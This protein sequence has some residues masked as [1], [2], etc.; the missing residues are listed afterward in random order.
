MAPVTE[1]VERS[2]G[3]ASSFK[4]DFFSVGIHESAVKK[5]K[6][7]YDYHMVS[8]QLDFCFWAYHAIIVFI[9]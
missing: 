7:K 6:Y 8:G 3:K 9:F 1:R 4:R 5:L 2:V